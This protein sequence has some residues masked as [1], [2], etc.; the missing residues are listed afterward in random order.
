MKIRTQS[1]LTSACIALLAAT[2]ASPVNAQRREGLPRN[3]DGSINAGVPNGVFTVI[4]VDSYGQTVQMRGASGSP[5]S[6]HVGSDIY[7][8]SKLKAGDRVQVNFLAP[9]GLS[10]K[11]SAANIWP[12]Q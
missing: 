1:L 2:L 12:S 6:V 3:Q 11:L 9:D 10:N 8:I 7:D 5:F 4:S